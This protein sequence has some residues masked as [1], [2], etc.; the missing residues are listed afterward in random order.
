MA[1][2]RLGITAATQRKKAGQGARPLSARETEVLHW[3]RAGKRN[4]EIAQLLGLSALTVKN[5]LQRIYQVLE[6]RNRTEA[7]AR[8]RAWRLLAEE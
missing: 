1:L 3:L 2:A 5:H 8:C 7:V 4:E 6:V